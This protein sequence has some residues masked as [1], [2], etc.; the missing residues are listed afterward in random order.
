MKFNSAV[1]Y[2]WQWGSPGSNAGQ[3]DSPFGV[4]IGT[5]KFSDGVS[6]AGIGVV[7]NPA[8]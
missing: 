2:Y 7:Y 8:S 6:K 5:R 3:F 1:T 4:A